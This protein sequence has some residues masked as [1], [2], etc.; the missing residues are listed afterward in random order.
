[1]GRLV[2]GAKARAI[3][4]PLPTKGLPRDPAERM[5]RWV[6]RF[7]VVPRG[8]GARK[9]MRLAP[10]QKALIRDT[11][12]PGIRSALWSMPR[13]Q[14]KTTFSAALALHALFDDTVHDP[15]VL[16][17][18]SDERTATILLDT[19]RRMVE[20]NPL[21]ADRVV[22]YKDRLV[23]PMTSGVLRALP[24]TESAL[25]GWN[26]SYLS[27]DELHLCDE[28]TWAACLTAVGK[29]DKSV[30]L[31]IST[32]GSNRDSVMYRLVEHGR[33]GLDPTF[34]FREFAAPAG[35]AVDDEAA[36]KIANPAIGA[37]FL[38]ADGLRATLKT[39]TESRFRQL[40]LGQWTDGAEN[41][42]VGYDQWM[43]L[44][45]PGEVIPDGAPV[46]L[47]FDGSVRSDATCLM[48]TTIPQSDDDRP[49]VQV[50]GIWARDKLRDDWEVPRD[51][52][53]ETVRKAFAQYDVVELCA[54]PYFWQAELQRWGA[55]FPGRVLEFPTNQ[56]QRMAKAT[57]AALAVILSDRIAHNGDPMLAVHVSNVRLRETPS[58]PVPVKESKNSEHKIDAAICM[59]L[60]VARALHHETHYR[61]QPLG[62]FWAL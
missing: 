36:W 20:L 6:E 28:P 48:A 5:I 57:D 19:A 62:G 13:G 30:L 61:P 7:I 35:C 59:I 26:P 16:A 17:V 50:I 34:H 27:L 24:S 15:E 44:A 53:D 55:E 9:P 60:G 22:P 54:D 47:S 2:G 51:E 46:V 33:E 45:K 18:A 40:R 41:G 29:R 3:T 37:G 32:P 1:M 8:F 56:P 31:A 39:T 42:W 12:T 43:G 14:G 4:E 38:S 25:H 52:V 58:G 10:F 49:F 11:F 23:C 21:L